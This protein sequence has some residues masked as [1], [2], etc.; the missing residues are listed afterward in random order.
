M[1]KL[2]PFHVAV[3]IYD[4]EEARKFYGESIGL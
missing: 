1:R 3:P 2:T 4:L